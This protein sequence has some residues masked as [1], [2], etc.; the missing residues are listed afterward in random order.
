MAKRDYYDV[1]GVN[2]SASQE[3]LKSAY[4]K[5][6]F[7]YHIEHMHAKISRSLYAINTAK[8]FLNTEILIILYKSLIHCHFLYCIQ[9]YSSVS[10]NAT[11]KYYFIPKNLCQKNIPWCAQKS[12]PYQ[13]NRCLELESIFATLC[14]NMKKVH[15]KFIKI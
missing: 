13:K 15:I 2:K 3:E 1:L 12:M 6:D 4:R 8:H 14:K 7:K 10:S 5:L 11:K 9:I